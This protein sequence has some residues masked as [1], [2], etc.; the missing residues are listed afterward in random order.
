[1]KIRKD[2]KRHRKEERV[3]MESGIEVKHLKGEDS[4]GMTPEARLEA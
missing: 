4:Q 2:T 3:K 1:M